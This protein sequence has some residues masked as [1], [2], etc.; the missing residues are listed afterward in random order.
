M[1]KTVTMINVF[2]MILK[3]ERAAFIYKTEISCIVIDFLLFNVF[4]KTESAI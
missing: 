3:F 1:L 2:E 4:I